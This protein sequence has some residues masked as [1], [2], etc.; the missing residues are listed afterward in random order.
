MQNKFPTKAILIG[1]DSPFQF[2][3]VKIVSKQNVVQ[4]HR[5]TQPFYEVDDEGYLVPEK[6]VAF[7]M[8]DAIEKYTELI[9]KQKEIIK[10][11]EFHLEAVKARNA[12]ASTGV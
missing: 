4:G 12:D 8:K 11:A 5:T 10:R 9:E 1:F 3:E 2:K 6:N 7:N